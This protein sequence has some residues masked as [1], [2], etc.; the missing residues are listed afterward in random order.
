M[1][2]N[3]F[4]FLCCLV[5]MVECGR[6]CMAFY[7]NDVVGPLH[8]YNVVVDDGKLGFSKALCVDLLFLRHDDY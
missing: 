1:F 8:V 6:C 3:D 5:G 4:N 7:L 2:S